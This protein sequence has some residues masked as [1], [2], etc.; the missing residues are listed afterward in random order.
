MQSLPAVAAAVSQ[1]DL[2][3]LVKVLYTTL[4]FVQYRID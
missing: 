4:M 3:S 1:Y 2:D